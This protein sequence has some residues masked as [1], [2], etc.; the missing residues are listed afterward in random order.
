MAEY[1]YVVSGISCEHCVTAITAEL[2]RLPGIA[3]IAIDLD[4]K[5]LT[6]CGDG[7]DDALLVEAIDEAGY[8][9]VPTI[10]GR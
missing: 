9:A 10:R 2:E 5:A 1:S 4:D 8:D 3:S 7:L 6:I